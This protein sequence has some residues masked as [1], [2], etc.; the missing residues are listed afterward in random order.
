MT[1]ELPPSFF[2]I[3]N[4]V[5]ISH[6]WK[7]NL[8]IRRTFLYNEAKKNEREGNGMLVLMSLKAVVFSSLFPVPFV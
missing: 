2:T 5:F 7:R 3:F 4:T 1:V 8:A 6:S